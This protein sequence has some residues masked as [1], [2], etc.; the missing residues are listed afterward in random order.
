MFNKFQKK[1]IYINE[2]ILTIIQK[3]TCW[4]NYSDSSWSILEIFPDFS[5]LFSPYSKTFSLKKIYQNRIFPRRIL[6]TFRGEYFKILL[7]FW[8]NWIKETSKTSNFW[9]IKINDLI[10]IWWKTRKIWRFFNFDCIQNK[11]DTYYQCNSSIN[12]KMRILKKSKKI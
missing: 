1:L 10:R 2:W 4:K 3:W 6:K 7:H 12:N 9:S 5:L 11:N 8:K